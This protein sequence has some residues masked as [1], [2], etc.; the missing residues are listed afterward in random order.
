MRLLDCGCGSSHLTFGAYHY[1]ANICRRGVVLRGVDTNEVR[2]TGRVTL[3]S[4]KRSCFI[5]RSGA[6]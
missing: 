4:I 1:L 5:K 2:E 3:W 6:G